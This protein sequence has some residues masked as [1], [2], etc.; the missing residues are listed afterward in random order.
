MAGVFVFAVTADGAG[1]RPPVLSGGVILPRTVGEGVVSVGDGADIG[2]TSGAI[3]SVAVLSAIVWGVFRRFRVGAVGVGR[4]AAGG[5]SPGSPVLR[6]AVILPAP[7]G[8][9][10]TDAGI[11]ELTAVVTVFVPV[12]A[13]PCGV[14]RAVACAGAD[15][16]AAA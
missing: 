7:V 16:R 8:I 4:R 11:H 2:R 15:I 3:L 12:T 10:V 6:C 14:G 13:R 5:T 9:A 1:F